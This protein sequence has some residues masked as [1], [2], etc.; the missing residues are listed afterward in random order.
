[1]ECI[2]KF[3]LKYEENGCLDKDFP[4]IHVLCNMIPHPRIH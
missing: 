2:L 1:M 3:D 4:Y